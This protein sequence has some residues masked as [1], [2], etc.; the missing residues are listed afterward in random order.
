MLHGEC[1]LGSNKTIQMSSPVLILCHTKMDD[2][3]NSTK[4]T[5]PF[6]LVLLIFNDF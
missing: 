6:S 1:V 3:Y 4:G 2:P 5:Y